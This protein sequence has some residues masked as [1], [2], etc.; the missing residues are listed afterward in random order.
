QHSVCL[1]N[2]LFS[3]CPSLLSGPMFGRL[4]SPGFPGEYANNQEQRWTLMAPPGYRLRLYFTHFHL[5]LSYLCEYDY[6]KV[7][8]RGTTRTLPRAGGQGPL[9]RAPGNDTFYSP[10]S[11]L[12]VTFRSDY[13]N[14]KPFTGF[15]AFYAAEDIDECQ[16]PP[17]QAP[18]CDHHCHNHLGGFYCSCRRGYVQDL[19]TSGPLSALCSGQVFTNRSGVLSSPE[20]PQPYPKL[21]SCTYSIHLEEGFSII[22]DF[23][24]S[25]DVETHPDTLCPYDSLKIQTDKEEYGPFCGTTLPPRIETKSNAVTITFVTDHS[26]DHTGWKIHY[27]TTGEGKWALDPSRRLFLVC[28]GAT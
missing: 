10:A 5:E 13:S 21:S 17:G 25:F 12:D 2:T 9:G 19:T 6:V 26:G 22:L 18:P 1:L 11:R 7:P 28:Q 27:T 20:Y 14:E 15:E 16:V 23:L 3:G 24:G 4:A 8:T